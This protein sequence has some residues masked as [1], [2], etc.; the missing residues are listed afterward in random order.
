MIFIITAAAILLLMRVT[1]LACFRC[2]QRYPMSGRAYLC[3]QCG[4]RNEDPGVLDVHY[5]YESAR[6]DL[7]NRKEWGVF[8]YLPLLPVR[9][10]GEVLPAGDTPLV[11]APKLAR[12]LGLSTIWLKDET[13]NPTRCLKDRATAVGVTMAL[14]NGYRDIYCA[15][16]GNAAIS[17]AG[18]SAHAGLGCHVFVPSDAS[19]TRLSWLRRYGADVR[20]SKGNYDQAYAEAEAEGCANGWYSRNCAFNP[21][22]VEGKKTVGL[23]MAE[24]FGDRVPDVVIAPAGDGCTPAGLGKGLR[25]ARMLGWIDRLPRLIGVQ[26]AAVSP[27]VERFNGRPVTNSFGE[28]KAKSIR[29]TKP[30]NALRLLSE[31]HLAKGEMIAVDDEAIAQA[32]R[33]LAE[34]AGMIAEFT[35]AATLAALREIAPRMQGG[36][37]ALVITGGRLD[38]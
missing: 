2:G 25:E 36:S 5:D 12:L 13:R 6:S 3:P 35:S 38:D 19:E 1:H 28:T 8:R 31:L 32:Q 9:Q 30:R 37:A 15:S 34:E 16:Q 27:L 23:E 17:L 14:E 33:M 11:A 24:Q 29:V 22:L 4:D 26:A 7:A 20:V 21:F 10:V 18:F